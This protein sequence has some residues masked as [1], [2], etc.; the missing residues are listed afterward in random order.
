MN[1]L[2]HW[3]ISAERR[4]R[5][6]E[7]LFVLLV[8]ACYAGA[9]DARGATAPATDAV[10]LAWNEIAVQAVGGTPPSPSTRAMAAVQV[11]VFEAVD[12][13]TRRYQP[14]LGTIAAPSDA[15]PEA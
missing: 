7:T 12:A 4:R 10:V 5:C 15:S 3:M 13:I 14:Y 11:A 6:R 2:H 1:F 8:A 9:F